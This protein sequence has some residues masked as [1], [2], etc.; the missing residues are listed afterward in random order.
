MGNAFPKASSFGQHL[1]IITGVLRHDVLQNM[2]NAFPKASSFIEIMKNVSGENDL[3]RGERVQHL[4]SVLWWI[5]GTTVCQQNVVW[6][7]KN[8]TLSVTY[9]GIKQLFH[10]AIQHA[11]YFYTNFTKGNFT[12]DLLAAFGDSCSRARA[13]REVISTYTYS[14]A[15]LCTIKIWRKL[16]INWLLF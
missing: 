7:N 4:L 3:H 16:F 1:K 2:G 8:N 12:V 6:C 13:V 14:H 9:F 10:I 15:D 5:I 11:Q